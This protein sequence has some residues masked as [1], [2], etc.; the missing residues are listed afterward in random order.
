MKRR[1]L[2]L[3]IFSIL[4]FGCSEKGKY[5]VNIVTT[6]KFSSI[7]ETIIEKIDKEDIPSLSVAVVEN[8]EII[9]MESFGYA[10]KENKIKATPNTL[11]TIASISKPITATGIMKLVEDGKLDLDANIETYLDNIKLKYYTN[12]S[13]KVTC[14]NLLSHT[15]GLP[16]HFQYFYDDD[17]VAIPDV[18]QVVDQYGIIVKP[19]SSKYVYANLGYGILG[20]IIS[21][22]TGKNFNDYMTEE[23][24]TPM[25]MTQ[26]TLDISS[27]TKNKLAKRYDIKGNL[28]P[29]SFADTP[30]AANVS[31]SI[32][33]LIQFGMFHLG[34]ASEN[35]APLLG[36]K[37]IHSMQQK[38]YPDN[39]NGRN[40][41]GLGW[42]INDND[43]KY[44][45]VY[46]AGGMDGVDAMIR[47]LPEKNIVVAAISNQYT[48]F[49]H[50][51]TEQIL[52][53]M[54]PDLKSVETK[55]AQ[56]QEAAVQKV[57][58]EIKQSDLIGSWKGNIVTNN[59]QIPIELVFQEDGD[60]HVNMPVQFKSMI[61][62][63]H[64][65]EVK[66]KM[67]LNKWY[68]TNGHLMGWYAENIPG[69]HLLR[70]PQITMLDLEYKTGKLIGTAV[71]MASNSTRMHYGLSYYLE[72]EKKDKK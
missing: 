59:S 62:Q 13:N 34:N 65:Y 35:A 53:E 16:M 32:H 38:Q 52:L 45:M 3:T 41:Y 47:L 29:F 44:K 20:E 11:Y 56:K 23:I 17:T 22:I 50:Q 43:Y 36:M 60:I 40:T 46:H 28:I 31:T 71:A 10:D 12:D 8:G 5:D 64:I 7:K 25:G 55:Q 67:L 42:F 49:T 19:P 39:A 27:K 6:D 51:L 54:I 57:S 70:C 26:T 21:K 68:F 66:H 1:L 9:W 48:E 69:E 61:L 30:G 63:T 4:I 15:S 72:L 14:R 58:K 24:F 18:M 2:I 33:D 37:T